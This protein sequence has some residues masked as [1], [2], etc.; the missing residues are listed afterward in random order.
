MGYTEAMRSQVAQAS[1][2]PTLLSNR[3]VADA[4]AHLLA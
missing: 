2:R 4:L 1:G 3:F